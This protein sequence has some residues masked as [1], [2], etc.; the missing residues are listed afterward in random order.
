[1]ALVSFAS[2]SAQAR[3]QGCGKSAPAASRGAGS[4]NPGWEQGPGTTVGH[5]PC[6][7]SSAPLEAAG[8]GGPRQMVT[9][10]V[11][12]GSRLWPPLLL[13]QREQN[14][15]YVLLSPPLPQ[16]PAAPVMTPQRRRQLLELLLKLGLDPEAPGG[17]G[18]SDGALAP[19]EEALSHRSAG[20]PVDHEQL[21]FLG[22]AVLRLAAS[23]YLR[24]HHPQLSVGQ[25]SALRAQLVSDRWL[26]ELALE[27]GLESRLHLG[28]IAAGDRA[29]RATVL[30][31]CCEALIGGLFV[32]WGGSDG[33]LEPV[34]QWLTPHWQRTSA[35]LLDDPHRHNW[36]SALQEWSQG[37]HLG[38]PSYRSDERSRSHGDPRR[39][40]CVVSI[41]SEACGEGWGGSRREAEQ[42]AARA[43]LAALGISSPAAGSEAAM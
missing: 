41:G 13:D 1:M 15:A 36:K 35:E 14:P 30:A 29:G 17:P 32:A 20:R 3:V 8:N 27:C 19:I 4:V 11:R 26:G 28:P 23:L 6:P 31:E 16:P 7:D 40:A 42:Q 22:D 34:L 37:Q 10:P 24:R 43:A 38:L 33:G 9:P 2:L 25:A 5:L 18:V 21:E 12:Q 39:F